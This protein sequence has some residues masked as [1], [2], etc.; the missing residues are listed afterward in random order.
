MKT[1]KF[2]LA[3]LAMAMLRTTVC[4][5]QNVVG[6]NSD[7]NGALSVKCNTEYTDSVYNFK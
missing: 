5:A 4:M 3:I 7:A 6:T 2:L 1:L